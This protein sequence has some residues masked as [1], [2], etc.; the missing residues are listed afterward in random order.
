M[1]VLIENVIR[2]AKRNW[3][4][5]LAFA[6]MLRLFLPHIRKQT[7]RIIAAQ[8]FGL[9]YILFDLME[10]WPM[11]VIFDSV[12]LGKRLPKVLVPILG[13]LLD[14]HRLALL[15]ISIGLIMAIALLQGFCYYY[16]HLLTSM[17]AQQVLSSV[18][19]A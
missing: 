17:S 12:F 5:W 14:G 7:N 18:R 4:Q 1:T 15:N 13:G 10:P 3:Q 8:L 16:E 11:K 6:R 2:K 19:L 9:G